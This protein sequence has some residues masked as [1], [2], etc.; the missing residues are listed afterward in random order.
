MCNKTYDG[1]HIA[2]DFGSNNELGIVK[3]MYNI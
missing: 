3:H 2:F 1:M